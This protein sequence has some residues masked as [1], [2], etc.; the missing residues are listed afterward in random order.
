[1]CPLVLSKTNACQNY[2]SSRCIDVCCCLPS[3]WCETI[4]WVK[5]PAKFHLG[6]KIS[7]WHD[8]KYKSDKTYNFVNEIPKLTKKKNGNI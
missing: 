4:F 6:N 8:I 2:S 7:P 1:M 5:T 3:S